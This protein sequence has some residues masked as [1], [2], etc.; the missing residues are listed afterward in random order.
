MARSIERYSEE[1]ARDFPVRWEEHF[2]LPPRELPLV[3]CA[4]LDASLTGLIEKRLVDD[5]S[6]IRK[7]LG[8]D[9]NYY[10]PVANFGPRIDLARLLGLLTNVDVKTLHALRRLRN[11]MA[12]RVRFSYTD[13]AAQPLLEAL[14]AAWVCAPIADVMIRF[15]SWGNIGAAMPA[16]GQ[17]RWDQLKDELGSD[18][19]AGH[20]LVN[21]AY[22]GYELHLMVLHGKVSPIDQLEVFPDPEK[23]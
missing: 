2:A 13:T 4:V 18:P 12:H 10:A 11:A 7:F 16:P 19:G 3:A 20:I 5:P 1:L 17:Q 22:T 9:G 8:I 14:Y 6:L 15:M 21:S 23:K